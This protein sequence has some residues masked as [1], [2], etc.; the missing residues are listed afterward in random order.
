MYSVFLNI[1]IQGVVLLLFMGIMFGV[2][3]LYVGYLRGFKKI[4]D[5][6]LFGSAEKKRINQLRNGSEPVIVE[7][8][9]KPTEQHGTMESPLTSEE[10]VAYRYKIQKDDPG[11]GA[12]N[13]TITIENGSDSVP[14]YIEGEHDRVYVEPQNASI[15]MDREYENQGDIRPE[16]LEQ[17]SIIGPVNLSSHHHIEYIENEIEVGQK[18]VALGK[19]TDTRMDADFKIKETGDRFVVSDTDPSSTQKRLLYKGIAYSVVGGVFSLASLFIFY[20]L[21]VSI[22]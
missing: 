16:K 22:F 14:F 5:W 13:K 17:S 11:T 20:V 3:G 15:S 19:A 4:L 18:G 6:R 1:S 2:V 12:D 10:C 9:V 21:L 7:G 8:T